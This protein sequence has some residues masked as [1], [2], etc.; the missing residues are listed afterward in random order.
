MPP[1]NRVFLDAYHNLEGH[2]PPRPPGGPSC[3]N[4]SKRT[5]AKYGE[6]DRDSH[7]RAEA[8]ADR[9]RDFKDHSARAEFDVFTVRVDETEEKM[10]DASAKP[11]RRQSLGAAM[12]PPNCMRVDLVIL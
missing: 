6:A 11:S 8:Q 12:R 7:R 5:L 1:P 10:D 3:R 4:P 9:S 2:G